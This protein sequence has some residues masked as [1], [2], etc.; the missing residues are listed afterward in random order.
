MKVISGNEADLLAIRAKASQVLGYPKAPDFVG[1]CVKAPSPTEHE[2]AVFQAENVFYMSTDVRLE[3]LATDTRLTKAMRTKLAA[4][5][6][7]ATLR[8]SLSVDS[9][10]NK[11]PILE[12]KA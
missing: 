3:D 2:Y 4:L 12:E 1:Q 9:E 10:A 6:A 8:E 7:G 5:L 11:I